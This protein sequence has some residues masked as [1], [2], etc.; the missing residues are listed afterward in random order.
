MSAHGSK[1]SLKADF[2]LAIA[3]GICGY[4]ETA[5]M[6]IIYVTD[7]AKWGFTHPLNVGVFFA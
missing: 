5:C 1:Y 2:H 3:K 6:L 4:E 7:M